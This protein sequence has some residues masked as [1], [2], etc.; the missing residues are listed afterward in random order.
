MDIVDKAMRQTTSDAKN[1][2]GSGETIAS[3]GPL[4]PE[5][6]AVVVNDIQVSFD[7]VTFSMV[8]RASN[9][10]DVE[11]MEGDDEEPARSTG[12]DVRPREKE[13]REDQKIWSR[14]MSGKPAREAEE[15]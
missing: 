6:V 9:D 7:N 10:E 8:G 15:E 14:I 5:A 13:D 12:G 11:M 2:L 4:Q 1:R 3:E